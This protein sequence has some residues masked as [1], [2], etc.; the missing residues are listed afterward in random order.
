MKIS[1]IIGIIIIYSLAIGAFFMQI[2]K[3]KKEELEEFRVSFPNI[4]KLREIADSDCD[5]NLCNSYLYDKLVVKDSKID[6]ND[7]KYC[8]ECKNHYMSTDD[9][10]GV[11]KDGVEIPCSNKELCYEIIKY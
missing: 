1:H 3:K 11:Y 9:K 10:K 7:F 2:F 5:T 6:T 8:K 4:D